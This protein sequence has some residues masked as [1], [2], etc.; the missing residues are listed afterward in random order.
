MYVKYNTIFVV[1]FTYM[2]TIVYIDICRATDNYLCTVPTAL[3]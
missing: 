1:H 2:Y 3:L